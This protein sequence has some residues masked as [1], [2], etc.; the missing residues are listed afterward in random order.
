MKLLVNNTPSN[1][2]HINKMMNQIKS[3]ND[4]LLTS[5][6][7]LGREKK[8]R[9]R[10][11]LNFH[12]ILVFPAYLTILYLNNES[13]FSIPTNLRLVILFHTIYGILWVIK[14][15]NFPDYSWQAHA[16][17][18]SVFNMF[19]V[20]SILYYS[21]I[22]CNFPSTRC[23]GGNV[24]NSENEEILFQSLGVISYVFGIFCHFVSDAQKF[25]TLKYRKPRS[26]ITNG[27]F[28]YT[29]NPN[30]FGEVLIYVGY[31]F[32]S[33]IPFTIFLFMIVWILI[34][35][36]NMLHKDKRLSRHKGFAEYKSKTGLL[37]PNFVSILNDIKYIYV[38]IP[39]DD[40]DDYVIVG[41]TN[42]LHLV[43]EEKK[44][45]K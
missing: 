21:P 42:E 34:F 28:K 19:V 18:G 1:H 26:L 22:Y 33:G 38:D 20:L 35:I 14:D 30:Y 10:N 43:D 45:Y 7:I 12:K 31:A 15:I 39:D 6:P 23:P 27:L 16:T 40:G 11:A 17:L 5:I 3:F 41:K 36:P 24:V 32:L 29:R 44:K 4:Y 37:I 9:V 25:F 8:Y 13:L 2:Y